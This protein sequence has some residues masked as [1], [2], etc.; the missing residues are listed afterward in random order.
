[1]I[2]VGLAVCKSTPLETEDLRLKIRVELSHLGSVRPR[3]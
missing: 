3:T 2:V 1:M